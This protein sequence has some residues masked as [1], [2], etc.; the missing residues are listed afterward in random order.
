MLSIEE[1][2]LGPAPG[3]EDEDEVEQIK[4][5]IAAAERSRGDYHVESPS[6]GYGKYQITKD[7]TWKDWST[8]HFGEE[9]DITVP[10]NQ[11]DVMGAQIREWK[12][13]GYTPA[14]ML[15]EHNSGQPNEP[16]KG[17]NKYGEPYDTE[18]YVARG[19][20]SG[21]MSQDV[22]PEQGDE[23]L[24]IEERILG[25]RPQARAGRVDYVEAAKARVRA[26][27]ARAPQQKEPEK[28]KLSGGLWS[29]AKSAG[30]G[31]ARGVTTGVPGLGGSMMEFFGDVLGAEELAG[32][33]K[34]ISDWAEK[35][36]D[37]W[38]GKAP[39]E[40]LDWI[41]Y[42]GAE[43]FGPSAIPGGAIKLG[44]RSLMGIGGLVK[45]ARAVGEVATALKAAGSVEEAAAKAKEA[46]ALLDQ[47]KKAAKMAN[48]IGDFSVASAFGMQQYENT[49]AL[50]LE[51]ADQL[52]KDG[53]MVEAEI[54]RSKAYG[55]APALTGII[56]AIG[57]Y[58]GSKYLGKLMGLDEAAVAG[59]AGKQKL[60]DFF[61]TLGVEIGTE[62]GQ[63]GGQAAVEKY[64]GIRPTADI[65]REALSVIGPTAFLTII[66]GG[67]A[68]GASKGA[69]SALGLTKE[70]AEKRKKEV[71]EELDIEELEA[72]AEKATPWTREMADQWVTT[73][74]EKL[75]KHGI[76]VKPGTIGE[77][78]ILHVP[79][80]MSRPISEKDKA[81]DEIDARLGTG[82]DT[83]ENTGEVIGEDPLGRQI[84]VL[85][86][87][88][89]EKK[90]PKGALGKV[91]EG[92]IEVE[93]PAKEQEKVVEEPVAKA[94]EPVAKPEAK[95]VQ[96]EIEA[97]LTAA[98][99]D[100]A[101]APELTRLVESGEY[102]L[103][104][105]KEGI[106][107]RKK[108]VPAA[109]VP[110][111]EP[112]A[113][114]PVAKAPVAKAPV[115]K[116]T[117]PT[118]I[119]EEI[120][121]L[122]DEMWRKAT[123]PE[124]VRLLEEQID[125]R[126]DELRKAKVPLAKIEE[127]KALMKLRV[128]HAEAVRKRQGVKTKA[129]TI[130]EKHMMALEKAEKENVEA[131]LARQAEMLTPIEGGPR[132]GEDAKQFEARKQ[133]RLN[134][135][136]RVRAQ[137][138]KD[139][140]AAA[141]GK[142]DMELAD[143]EKEAFATALKAKDEKALMATLARRY[144]KY[145]DPDEIADMAKA[146]V[147]QDYRDQLLVWGMED[148][149][150]RRA[151]E[152]YRKGT[153]EEQLATSAAAKAKKAAQRA[154]YAAQTGTT[155]GRPVERKYLKHF[156]NKTV[157][158]RFM[159]VRA[160]SGLDAAWDALPLIKEQV[161]KENAG[162]AEVAKEKVKA[163]PPKQK[164]VAEKPPAPDVFYNSFIG[165]TKDEIYNVFRDKNV[166]V[167]RVR[168]LAKY[169]GIT[170][171]AK[172]KREDLVRKIAMQGFTEKG[173]VKVVKEKKTKDQ[174]R[175]EAIVS[176][177]Q[178]E[179][180]AKGETPAPVAVEEPAV[181]E[182]AGVT[183]A[184]A[185]AMNESIRDR[186]RAIE[187]LRQDSSLTML[188]ALGQAK[189]ERLAGVK[190]IY[191]ERA[192]TPIEVP[193][194][195]AD[196][197]K[198]FSEA[199]V[200]GTVAMSGKISYNDKM[201]DP[202]DWVVAQKTQAAERNIEDRNAR[203][204]VL[205]G[206]IRTKRGSD[207][208]ELEKV[209]YGLPW[210]TAQEGIADLQAM[211][212]NAKQY[213]ADLKTANEY[214]KAKQP[215]EAGAAAAAARKAPYV[216]TRGIL[217][218]REAADLE[219]QG[220]LRLD[221]DKVEVETTNPFTKKT[222]TKTVYEFLGRKWGRD[223]NVF[224]VEEAGKYQGRFM[225]MLT[226]G[227]WLVTKEAEK[228]KRKGT[229]E[230]EAKVA[231]PKTLEDME[232]P[233]AA[234]GAPT[235]RL[236]P[237]SAVENE[238]I[239]VFN[240][241]VISPKTGRVEVS[242][243]GSLRGTKNAVVIETTM[244]PGSEEWLI[245]ARK[246]LRYP[247][248]GTVRTV[249]VKD[250]KGVLRR[251]N[252]G[253]YDNPQ[254]TTGGGLALS[255]RMPPG[256]TVYVMDKFRSGKPWVWIYRVG[257]IEPVGKRT[258]TLAAVTPAQLKAGPTVAEVARTVPEARFK[259]KDLTP[260]PKGMKVKQIPMRE[261]GMTPEERYDRAQW[262]AEERVL[263]VIGIEEQHTI[264]S[265]GGLLKQ[266]Y[267]EMA[268][269]A[270]ALRKDEEAKST[271]VKE[272][273]LDPETKRRYKRYEA[274]YTHAINYLENRLDKLQGKTPRH[275]VL[276][277]MN[278]LLAP[279]V[280]NVPVYISIPVEGLRKDLRAKYPRGTDTEQLMNRGDRF[281]I[282]KPMGAV[283]LRKTVKFNRVE[284]VWQAVEARKDLD[285]RSPEGRAEWE[286]LEGLDLGY[287]ERTP[288]LQRQVFAPNAVQTIFRKV[289]VPDEEG[290]G[291]GELAA[292]GYAEGRSEAAQEQ[293][294]PGAGGPGRAAAEQGGAAGVGGPAQAGQAYQPVSGE[295]GVHAAARAAAFAK[296][297]KGERGGAH[298]VGRET[299][300]G[301]HQVKIDGVIRNTV[302]GFQR[303]LRTMRNAYGG[304][305]LVVIHANEEVLEGSSF[306]D[307]IWLNDVVAS[308][309]DNGRFIVIGHRA[310]GRVTP[311]IFHHE[312][313]HVAHRNGYI[314]ESTIKSINAQAVKNA[315][316]V[317]AEAQRV[318]R[319][320]VGKLYNAASYLVNRME[321]IRTGT[322]IEDRLELVGN[323]HPKFASIIDLSNAGDRMSLEAEYDNSYWPNENTARE[324]AA[325]FRAADVVVDTSDMTTAY[326]AMMEYL[327]A[328][329]ATEAKVSL[330]DVVLNH[331][332]L[333]GELLADH[334]AS[335]PV[336]A[337]RLFDSIAERQ[338][339]EASKIPAAPGPQVR[340]TDMMTV[341]QTTGP[342]GQPTTN[343]SQPPTNPNNIVRLRAMEMPET[344]RFMKQAM[345]GSLDNLSLLPDLTT[346]YGEKG[347]FNTKTGKL[348]LSSKI[349]QSED[350]ALSVI[351]QQIGRIV[352]W[353]DEHLIGPARGN[354]LGRIAKLKKFMKKH[355]HDLASAPEITDELKQVSQTL[356]PFDEDNVDP[357]Y[358][359][360]RY[361][362]REL[363]SDA[364]SML[365]QDPGLLQ[366][367]APKFYAGFFE[368]L[369]KM[370]KVMNI[371]NNIQADL[372]DPV[373]LNQARLELT[374]KG[375]QDTKAKFDKEVEEEKLSQKAW[376]RVRAQDFYF[377][378][379]DKNQRTITAIKGLRKMGITLDPERDP[380]YWLS[381]APYVDNL[382]ARYQY[383]VNDQVIKVMVEKG[384]D[385]DD[386]DA[387][388]KYGR[389]IEYQLKGQ[390]FPGGYR[391]KTATD[392]YEALK[393]KVG[394]EKFHAM[395]ELKEKLFEM[396]QK[397]VTPH[398]EK[399]EILSDENLRLMKTNKDYVHFIGAKHIDQ[400]FT[401][402]GIFKGL[403]PQVYQTTGNLDDDLLSP[404][405][406]TVLKDMALIRATHQKM[407]VKTTVAAL[408]AFWGDEEVKDAK[409]GR[410]GML[411]NAPTGFETIIMMHKG[412]IKGFHVRPEVAKQF[413][414]DPYMAHHI[415]KTAL[416]I[417]NI[418][419][420]IFVR[421]NPV[422]I[423][424]NLP[425]DMVDSYKKMRG[426]TIPAL[427]K[428]MIASR[429][430]AWD[431]VFKDLWN[432]DVDEMMAGKMLVAGRAFDPTRETT[433]AAVSRMKQMQYM[434]GK[435]L[436]QA[437]TLRK[438]FYNAV[439]APV[440][441]FGQFT[442]AWT[443]IASYRLSKKYVDKLKAEKD[444]LEAIA[445]R[446]K[447][448][449]DRLKWL[450]DE[451]GWVAAPKKM[452]YDIR[453]RAG[454]PDIYRRGN[455]AWLYNSIFMFSNVGKEGWREH[456]SAL[457][458]EYRIHG[459][460][461][462]FASEYVWKTMKT[463]ILPKMLVLA[464]G[465]GWLG[466]YWKKFFDNISEYNKSVNIIIPTGM[467]DKGESTYLRIAPD[468]GAQM[469]GSVFYRMVNLIYEG[470]HSDKFQYNPTEWS[471]FFDF[472]LDTN[473]YGSVHPLLGL[474]LETLDLL[475]GAN[476]YDGFTS[477]PIVPDYIMKTGNRWLIASTFAG[478]A[479]EKMGA[480][481]L[482][483]NPA[484][485]FT[486][487]SETVPYQEKELY[488]ELSEKVPILGPMAWT[489][490]QIS[491][492]GK[493]QRYEWTATKAENA[494]SQRAYDR[495]Q[496]IW[497]SLEKQLDEGKKPTTT[498]ANS[499]YRE[500]VRNGTIDREETSWNSFKNMYTRYA[501]RTENSRE[502]DMIV[503]ARTN[504]EKAELL[505]TYQKVMPPEEY[506]K[507]VY[508][509]R[510]EG[511]L[512]SDVMSMVRKLR[513]QREKEGR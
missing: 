340:K 6:K 255:G 343:I 35:K 321:E 409:H 476:P 327:H 374:R 349:F 386:F 170:G 284:G 403:R 101:K 81:W 177:E 279:D 212:A 158:D 355:F 276:T 227:E 273:K 271:G 175:L 441:K 443:K 292:E 361:S 339:R 508:H 318:V 192:S 350:E 478:Y 231:A 172:G 393:G 180:V 488:T 52:E 362:S 188:E 61:K 49:K 267:G 390:A 74:N 309:I 316:Q 455:W 461:N 326:S 252:S 10:Q 198:R 159:E 53:K 364:V 420:S 513:W 389:V 183:D 154:D 184:E 86:V 348:K 473:P 368:Y 504:R 509:L 325:L 33:G 322:G 379:I 148:E 70:E 57:E 204:R 347:R 185:N 500:L 249:V 89:F 387:Y 103:E 151:E 239:P 507:I 46:A 417:S 394:S 438:K 45:D 19:L 197:Q 272:D 356:I 196:L 288:A 58:F 306:E 119:D 68:A 485:L 380:L 72:E 363:Y 308:S 486:F 482:G 217:S 422:W 435:D 24:S 469:I 166:T 445:S 328:A 226:P 99:M 242:A 153:V 3:T 181:E 331:G 453:N 401:D 293:I 114:E 94:P 233:A 264:E 278:R 247:E 11:E 268:T 202:E 454:T 426:F 307:I 118:G 96:P 391:L 63:A 492:Y 207:A 29:F 396:R 164:K 152:A 215:K 414:T 169:M 125:D 141:E 295:A 269:I 130:A 150:E 260:V 9:K 491:D 12:R 211:V 274:R 31:F 410:G 448:Q 147:D 115:A 143:R 40:T 483:K 302:S 369:H 315:K 230:K 216:E 373:K 451:L 243:K 209:S 41:A 116:A 397:Y 317:M 336:L 385:K 250:E 352:D 470:L 395:G 376:W 447:R 413:K 156:G 237:F 471:N 106:E 146:M 371:Y 25:P 511:M 472:V 133:D 236:L 90:Q 466:D 496:A 80:E 299:F 335:N 319:S 138:E 140:S 131:R 117:E 27:E 7:S 429:G 229:K 48:R 415:A 205:E 168:E 155:M 312:G 262:E 85:F 178:I 127:D 87:E 444:G 206:L 494:A 105:V 294:V 208:K 55:T 162:K 218:G 37:E 165:K 465:F 303:F 495:R 179:A 34:G 462:L 120:A 17:V 256:S 189:A 91:L 399:S 423:I 442:E 163:A 241:A 50:A 224:L 512:T 320:G 433:D 210:K 244:S 383:H 64:S 381:E 289:G 129:E 502:V 283:D 83:D 4:S 173:P 112:A 305:G 201:V 353:M 225:R 323:R 285:L 407:A 245:G 157:F 98:G 452:A 332:D 282:T 253:K 21:G 186:A 132:A 405:L 126:V 92:E 124:D 503:F 66:T 365:V 228:E 32:V 222:T 270:P 345:G 354:I 459:S 474:S 313:T 42:K 1:S 497:H 30:L 432:S 304:T 506:N 121:R 144:A 88:K 297:A 36:G 456:W 23:D 182:Y 408:R 95:A 246:F 446:S 489:Y 93:A 449:D 62:V 65:L 100:V 5:M 428:E 113:K 122:E 13:K 135:I 136:A 314:D 464:A 171:Y 431:Y 194:G 107:K 191:E 421:Y 310:V 232:I 174:E 67:F 97:A 28:S 280:A 382:M 108:V 234:G 76:T 425:R 357:A 291:G 481:I 404:F 505:T 493:R 275:G 457:T 142:R 484:G 44:L 104:Q 43:M 18:E 324:M 286:A 167:K 384:I 346:K 377:H 259:G 82:A 439:V 480:R 221:F 490:W 458:D 213:V 358:R 298:F 214:W 311:S 128:A 111:K 15:R 2:I 161:A 54:M 329:L 16:R 102:T 440:D 342:P 370:P 330:D 367:I 110:E 60:M 416:F 238:L 411:E 477:K 26:L 388:L 137:Q 235:I 499:L 392:Q 79:A 510:R 434:Y 398:V 20:K 145:A 266:I 337:D 334:V 290:E 351:A 487:R 59:R 254:D 199:M 419:K 437:D 430:V 277:A 467:T 187:I 134:Y 38:Y 77:D 360:H 109:V 240:R 22:Q 258:K 300:K 460:K 84:R 71:E 436:K 463:T 176:G 501:L 372:S 248:S 195:T 427:V 475:R 219:E 73:R 14:Q 375:F 75:A 51:A 149:G 498:A 251:D 424:R 47:A 341:Q 333:Q 56:E 263:T 203:I 8:R 39:E 359:R 123:I 193:K 378:F 366:K 281:A 406:A 402:Q 139:S 450:K 200:R 400:L 344:V 301:E 160:I 78:G 257:P 265:V 412:V 223:P 479:A 69:T 287:V 220:R 338:E 190:K 296:D 418:S 468:Y 261:V